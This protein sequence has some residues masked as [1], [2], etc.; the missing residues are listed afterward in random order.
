MGRATSRN[1]HT[2]S[3]A[4][5]QTGGHR[6]RVVTKQAKVELTSWNKFRTESLAVA[7]ELLG[8]RHAFTFN[9]HS[10]EI[11][12]PSAER[13][14]EGEPS[15]SFVGDRIAVS[16]WQ[17]TQHG[18][19]EALEAYVKDVDL[20]VSIPGRTSI[21]AQALTVPPN[22]Y[23][24]LSVSQQKHLDTLVSDYGNLS[25]QIFDLWMRT[26]RWKADFYRIGLPS[27]VGDQT[28]SWSTY[29]REKN[30]QK[31]VWA[32]GLVGMSYV[33]KVVTPEIWN[34]VS[35]AL[36][37][38]ESP[39][40][41]FDLLCDARIH[42]ERGDLQRAVVDA[43]VAAETYMRTKV[44]EGLPSN[45]DAALRWYINEANVRQ[46]VERFFPERLDTQQVKRYRGLKSDLHKLFSDRNTILHS[47]QKGGL[48]AQYCGKL[49]KR[50]NDLVSL[51]P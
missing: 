15:G 17:V 43:A 39:P 27:S 19:W 46:V 16:S 38:G 13:L 21:A 49:I 1:P 45:L 35:A 51:A 9:G 5:R 42:L 34:L 31:D 29:L 10:I 40:I 6:I 32:S 41:H 4:G 33:P 37:A 24:A 47:G 14:P 12:L 50:V 11:S 44:E 23:E 36:N 30:T 48:T 25:R 28:T 26:L 22:A 20:V 3:I 7:P 18:R 8:H 2:G